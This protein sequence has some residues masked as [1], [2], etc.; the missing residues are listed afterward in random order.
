MIP[1]IGGKRK[2]CDYEAGMKEK[3]LIPT[4]AGKIVRKT[5][6]HTRDP[7]ATSLHSLPQELF[8]HLLSF[9]GPTCRSIISLASLDRQHRHLMQVVAN[10]VLNGA[11][12]RRSVFRNGICPL[13]QS[14]SSISVLVRHARKCR[15]VLVKVEA[16]RLA[17]ENMGNSAETMRVP[18]GT[19]VG[20][21]P[22]EVNRTQYDVD[23]IDKALSLAIELLD[24]TASTSLKNLTQPHL[25]PQHPCLLRI[26]L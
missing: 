14:E 13:S 11:T 3:G 12:S 18:S 23:L 21:I 9:L 8:Y 16:L 25:V 7:S 15:E 10:A 4:Q 19:S 1:T 6:S 20:R 2:W 24:S 17:L 5:L 22:D 26:E